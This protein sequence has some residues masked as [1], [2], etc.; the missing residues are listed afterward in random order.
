[1]LV[2]GEAVVAHIDAAD[3]ERVHNLE[4]DRER[5]Q[6]HVEERGHFVVGLD[7][8]GG[9]A[10]VDAPCAGK[11]EQGAGH[12]GAVASPRRDLVVPDVEL[13][14]EVEPPTEVAVVRLGDGVLVEGERGHFGF[15]DM[16]FILDPQY[17]KFEQSNSSFH[18]TFP[19]MYNNK[20]SFCG[21]IQ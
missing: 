20:F 9:S 4:G 8:R 17:C 5:E 15:E 12:H 2:V 13:D 16:D 6:K 14:A 18:L 7:G 1:M 10:P 3:P 21:S 19:C 11:M